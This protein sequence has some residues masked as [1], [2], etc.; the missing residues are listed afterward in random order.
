M[1][2]VERRE[3]IS[4]TRPPSPTNVRPLDNLKIWLEY[5]DGVKGIVDLS[6]MRDKGVFKAWNDRSFFER[7]P[8]RRERRCLLGLRFQRRRV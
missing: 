7:V 8:H 2:T 5:D 3:R 1:A 6:D 4:R